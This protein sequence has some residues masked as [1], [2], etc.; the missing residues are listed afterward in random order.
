MRADSSA[1]SLSSGRPST[2]SGH[3]SHTSTSATASSLDDEE[4]VD[5]TSD[6]NSP[7]RL[8][9]AGSGSPSRKRG[10]QGRSRPSTVGS[11]VG[12]VETA[13]SRIS[14]KQQQSKNVRGLLT[15]GTRGMD[16]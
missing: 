7:L 16:R 9:H 14:L 3:T 8:P 6:P 10:G 12:S 11:T 13:M 15:K 5:V 4:D 1:G 2:S